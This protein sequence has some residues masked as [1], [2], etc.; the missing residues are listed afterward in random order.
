MGYHLVSAK[1]LIFTNQFFSQYPKPC[2]SAFVGFPGFCYILSIV[3]NKFVHYFLIDPVLL[4][5]L[6]VHSWKKSWFEGRHYCGAV[7]A[8][9]FALFGGV[10]LHFLQY[11]P[12]LTCHNISV[13]VVESI[14]LRVEPPRSTI[15]NG[16]SLASCSFWG[17]SLSQKVAPKLIILCFKIDS[18]NFIFLLGVSCLVSMSVGHIANFTTEI[19]KPTFWEKEACSFEWPL[20]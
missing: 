15:G 11:I 18:L 2:S 9:A 3:A 19:E 14:T 1:I 20:P 6:I 10:I 7:S 12:Y 5:S 4:K 17:L 13:A 16:N 8:A